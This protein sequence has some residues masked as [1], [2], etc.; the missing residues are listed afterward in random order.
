M[1]LHSLE[2]HAET[3]PLALLL[4]R[5]STRCVRDTVRYWWLTKDW[6]QRYNETEPVYNILRSAPVFYNNGDN[7]QSSTYVH[8]LLISN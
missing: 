4:L 7:V 2:Q 8:L 3:E 6:T 5:G 1:E